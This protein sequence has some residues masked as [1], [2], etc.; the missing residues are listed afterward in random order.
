MR[1]GRR[2]PVIRIL[3]WLCRAALDAASWVSHALEFRCH[4]IPGV[5]PR[6]ELSHRSLQVPARHPDIPLGRG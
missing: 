3:Y 5:P 2:G 6:L 4:K 1:N